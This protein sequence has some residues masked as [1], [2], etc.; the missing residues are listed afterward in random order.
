MTTDKAGNSFASAPVAVL[1]DN[2]APTG[3]LTAPAANAD[4]A[5]RYR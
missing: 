3:S 5:A 4:L 2:T 1:V